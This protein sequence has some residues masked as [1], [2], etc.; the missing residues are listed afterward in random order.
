MLH[1]RRVSA[2]VACGGFPSASPQRR[3]VLR[4]R[5]GGCRRPGVATIF[6]AEAAR[7]GDS[8]VLST[9]GA[10]AVLCRPAVPDL[11]LPVRVCCVGP[12]CAIDLQLVTAV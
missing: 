1:L 2:A 8:L 3:A 11:N 5:D 10:H 6:A 7:C 4:D 12:L 9:A